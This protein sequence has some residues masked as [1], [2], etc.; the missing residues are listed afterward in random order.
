MK[1]N[2]LCLIVVLIIGI[3]A[4]VWFNIKEDTDVDDDVV[5]LKELP[6]PEVTG[7]ERGKLGIDKNIN[8]LNI[9]EYLGRSDSVYRDMRMLEDPGNY[10]AIGGD[11][12]LSGY[13]KGFEIVSLPYIIPVSGLPEEVGDTYIG[14]T[15]FRLND[16]KYVANYEESL[17]IIEELFPKDKY[18]FLMCGG[19][20]YAGMTK[21]FLVSLGWDS[22][23]IYN[24]GGYWYYDG[25]NNISVKKIVDGKIIYD[26]ASVPYHEIDFSKL[27]KIKIEPNII[28]E[29]IKLSDE[30]YGKTSDE[31]F[32]IELNLR[33]KTTIFRTDT[34]EGKMKAEN[35]FNDLVS[36]KV[37]IIN[38]LMDS[39]KSFVIRV[40]P[41]EEACV[42]IPDI[43][44]VLT[45]SARRFFYNNN[46]YSYEIN[47][48]IFRGTYLYNTIKYP[49]AVI[50]V[51]DGEV[52]AYID[53]NK[54]LIESDEKLENWIKTYVKLDK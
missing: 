4:F 26:F 22:D 44:F 45:N 20:G 35:I 31:V 39:K 40:I 28:K 36:K 1:K 15:L 17:S 8:E 34:P 10:E 16:G 47:L 41:T 33:E 49:P 38:D 42:T 21:E 53:A 9:D 24:V 6:K 29:P 2:L 25:K 30:Y 18:I 52:Y 19:G 12:Y 7:G 23:K 51:K 54:D 14:D 3:S 11:S 27:N 46:I 48:P 43:E 50:V 37:N 13:V 32:D 5:E